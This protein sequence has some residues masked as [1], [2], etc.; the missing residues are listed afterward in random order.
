MGPFQEFPFQCHISPFLTRDKPNSNNKRVILDLS[1]PQSKSVNDGVSKDL[2]LNTFFELNY[3]S[4]DTVVNRLK[5]LG[6]EALLYK[7]DIS[8][9]FRHIR[10]DPGDLDLLG[11][12][13]D[14]LFLEC[15]LQFGFRHGSVFF[16]RCTDAVRYIMSKK[17]K[18]PY[19]CNYIDDLIYT[20]LPQEIHSS[21]TTL[22]ALLQELGLEISQSKLVPPTT[23][24]VCLG[25]EI[26]TVRRTLEISAE[27]LSEIHTICQKFACKRKVTKNQLQSLLGSLLY[28][29]KCIKPAR[30]FL[31]RMLQLLREYT[32]KSTIHLGAGFL[33][34][35][36]WF[37]TFLLQFNGVTFFDY[38]EPDH[39]VYLDACL[40]GFGGVFANKIYA[41]HIPLAFKNYT[42][43]HLKILNIVVA[44]KI[45]G[46]I[47]K[48]QVLDIKC[49]NMAVV[50]VLRSG[51]AR[52]PILAT[53]ARNIWLLTAIF[54]IQLTATHIPGVQNTKK[55]GP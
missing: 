50:E 9:A 42:I 48:N 19:L 44:L 52:D 47:W 29:T 13:H 22:I 1:F 53:C 16:Q 8:R 45:W 38:K 14:Q 15:T 30:F 24:A 6:S 39:T 35:L 11:L 4:V 46:D 55:S 26:D 43:V 27:K 32:D 51:K 54:N 41:L 2:Y 20:G 18:F 23:T 33:R 36:N 10:I 49:D 34:D 3:P 21:Y 12:K 7:I 25:I 37:N 5:V 17:F 40:T 31:N 28:I